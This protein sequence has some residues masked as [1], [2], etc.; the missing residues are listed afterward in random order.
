MIEKF[1]QNVLGVLK[2]LQQAG[3]PSWFVGGCVRDALLNISFIDYDIATSATPLEM[4]NVLQ[5]FE[6]DKTFQKY[7]CIKVKI[8]NIWAELTTLRCDVQNFGRHANVEF[9]KD[10]SKEIG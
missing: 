7:G 10:I 1:N 3:F 5:N 9:T 8:D 4:L 6:L 2:N